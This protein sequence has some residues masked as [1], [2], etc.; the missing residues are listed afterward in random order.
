MLNDS[1]PEYCTGTQ[2][3]ALRRRFPPPWSVEDIGAP[4]VVIDII[5]FRFIVALTRHKS[6]FT[7]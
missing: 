4:F 6:V 3:Q 5:Y 2:L 1:I 7:D